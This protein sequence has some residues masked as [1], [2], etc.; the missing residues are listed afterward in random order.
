M[1][2]SGRLVKMEVDYSEMVEQRLPEV[3]EMAK[4]GKVEEALDSLLSLEKQTRLASDAQ[5]TGKVLKAIVQ[6]CFD[7]QE[8]DLLNEHILILTKKRGQLKTCPLTCSGCGLNGRAVLPVCGAGSRP[9]YQA[10]VD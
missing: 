2:D 3:Q 7:L 8:W 5:S 9:S 6:M 10:Q 1:A 4:N